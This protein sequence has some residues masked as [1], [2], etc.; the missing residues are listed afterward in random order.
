MKRYWLAVY[1]G[2]PMSGAGQVTGNID[3]WTEGPGNWTLSDVRNL[4]GTLKRE[5]SASFIRITN[6]IP[7]EPPQE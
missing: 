1:D 2:K 4:E 5:N 3:V 7:L 6:I